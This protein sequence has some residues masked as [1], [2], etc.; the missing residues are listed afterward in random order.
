MLHLPQA[1][2]EVLGPGDVTAT[3]APAKTPPP[4][5]KHSQHSLPPHP[6][7]GTQT[8]TVFTHS[9]TTTLTREDLL[10]PAFVTGLNCPDQP[11][12]GH[13]ALYKLQLFPP[14]PS[15]KSQGGVGVGLFY[16]P[17]AASP[18]FLPSGYHRMG[19][20]RVVATTGSSI[21]PSTAKEQLK[22]RLH[23]QPETMQETWLETSAPAA[24]AC[25]PPGEQAIS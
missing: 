23:H 16:S 5:K 25:S 4:L 1:H 17:G 7:Q 3:T 2:Q 18:V 15:T 20:S 19:L 10:G 21:A 24:C 11:H 9:K 8:C 14:F 12:L 22:A 6:Q 13:P